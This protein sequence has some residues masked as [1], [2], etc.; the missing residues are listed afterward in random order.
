MAEPGHAGG[1][2]EGL[3]AEVRRW[4]A[5]AEA[6][7]AELD[8]CNSLEALVSAERD[9]L[10]TQL[11]AQAA[12]MQVLRVLGADEFRIILWFESS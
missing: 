9:E 11:R 4:R 1:E 8:E 7:R 6:L 5:T 3:Q 12:R 10:A 2:A